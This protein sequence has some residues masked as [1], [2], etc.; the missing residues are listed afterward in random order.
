MLENSSS[1]KFIHPNTTDHKL[2]GL[3]FDGHGVWK[4]TVSY[5]LKLDS[6]KNQLTP[7]QAYRKSYLETGKEVKLIQR[8]EVKCSKN[9]QKYNDAA[10]KIQKLY[11]GGKYRFAFLQIR[12]RL[13][14]DLQYRRTLE[15]ASDCCSKENY[16]EALS[17][18]DSLNIPLTTE[19]ME[20]KIKIA[21]T[22]NLFELCERT[23]KGVIGLV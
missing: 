14:A 9:P 6:I 15:K 18:I 10:T 23:C 22:L 5:K 21:Y 19:I 17:I 20:L 2:H 3:H 16:D 13:F 8:L 12:D 11:R 1:N 4:P 7:A